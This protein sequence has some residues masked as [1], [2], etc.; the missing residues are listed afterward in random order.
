VVKE[1][2]GKGVVI[3]VLNKLYSHPPNPL[4]KGELQGLYLSVG[5]NGK[6]FM[7]CKGRRYASPFLK[8]VRGM[9]F[10]LYFFYHLKISTLYTPWSFSPFLKGVR[11]NL[12]TILLLPPKNQHII[13][14]L[15]LFPLF[16]GG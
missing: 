8:G 9:T 16:E 2:S 7:L 13:Y 12:H 11:G 4:Q 14:A 6:F 10:T 3:K 1:V 15:V 5:K